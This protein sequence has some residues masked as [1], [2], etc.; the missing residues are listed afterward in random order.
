[1]HIAYKAQNKLQG[2]FHR[3]GIMLTVGLST[4]VNQPGLIVEDYRLP[5]HYK[6]Y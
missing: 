4:E 6:S 5:T 2:L 1:M 3:L